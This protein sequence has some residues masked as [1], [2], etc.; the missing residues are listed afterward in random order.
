[1]AKKSGNKHTFVRQISLKRLIGP[2]VVIDISEKALANRDYQVGIEDFATWESAYGNLPE[3]SIVFLHTGYGQY[4]PDAM[5]YMGT[6]KRGSDAVAELHFPG[7]H[8]DAARWLVDNRKISAIGLDTPSIDYGQSELFESHQILF[9]K[10][11]LAFENVANLDQLPATGASVI[12]LPMK[13]KGGSGGPLR[14]IAL[15]PNNQS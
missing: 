11:I 8:V 1:M 5:K 4:W 9:D 3:N 7:L 14:I 10:N 2:A 12:A 13:I 6:D 15:V